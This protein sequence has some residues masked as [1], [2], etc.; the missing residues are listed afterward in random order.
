MK[1]I[2]ASLALLLTFS[3]AAHSQVL[4]SLLLGDKLN[5][6]GLE[7]GLEG[8][9][10]WSTI[11]NMEGKQSLAQFNLGFYFDIRMKNRLSLYTGVLVKG[12]LGQNGLRD[13]DLEFLDSDVYVENGTYSQV[14]N[15]FLVPALMKYKIKKKWYVEAGP[16]AGLM[17]GAWVEFNSSS[18]ERDATIKDYNESAINRIDFGMIGGFGYKLKE[19]NGMTIG[20]KYYYGFLDVYKDRSG[21]NNESIFV[22]FNVPIGAGKAKEAAAEENQSQ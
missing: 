14:L 9:F 18:D 6:D 13:S 8:G 20:V 15:Y 11:G 10:N 16:Q 2:L 4:I 19:S 3:H 21:T 22:K 5:S 1:K 17:Y 7:F 12:G